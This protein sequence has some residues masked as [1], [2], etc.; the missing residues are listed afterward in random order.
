MSLPTIQNPFA[1]AQ[2]TFEDEMCAMCPSMTYQQ[3][4]IGFCVCCGCG[5][6]LSF[7]GTLMLLSKD[8]WKKRV[9]NFA[10]LYVFGNFIAIAATGFLIGPRR[11][12]KKM[13][14]KTRRFAC[15]FWLLMLIVTFVLG[16]SGVDVGWVLLAL[17]IQICAGIWYSASYIPYRRRMIIKLFQGTCFA[18]C[19][20]ACDPVIKHAT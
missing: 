13:F 18:P 9:T 17:F 6:A 12:C 1:P 7:M 19:P 3:R 10:I 16:L 11:Q 8:P 14:S 4:L 20:Q 5:Y 2:P 15:I